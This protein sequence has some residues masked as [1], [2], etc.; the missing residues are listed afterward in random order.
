MTKGIDCST[1]LTAATAAKIAAAGY[2][3]AARYLVPQGY[4]KRI[5][6]AEAEAITAAG[7]QI[8]SVFETTAARPA[9]GAKNGYVDGVAAYGEAL[10]IGQ[11]KGSAIYF[12][13]DYD[14]QPD[15]YDSIDAY[16]R[17]AG[18]Q[19]PGYKVGVYGSFTVIEAML[20]R[21]AAEC[22]WQ[23]YAWSR[24]KKSALANIFQHLNGQT[25]AGVGVDFN[26]SYGNEGW[27]NTKPVEELKPKM[28]LDDA[29]AVIASLQKLWGLTKTQKEKDEIHRQANAVR[30]AHGIPIQ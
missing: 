4:F 24:G 22:G 12:A 21:S 5:T 18:S 9:G 7:M 10:A 23:T 3:F 13:V 25:L 1:P 16:L 14:A 19:I 20:S 29:K 8:V 26:E 30:K 28:S 17:A 27:W 11:P 6:K 2:G 15:D